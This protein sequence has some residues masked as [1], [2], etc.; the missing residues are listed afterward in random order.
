MSQLPIRVFEDQSDRAAA[1]AQTASATSDKAEAEITGAVMVALE[2]RPC[3][4]EWDV[5]SR[6]PLGG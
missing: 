2:R 1:T 3:S 6:I 5:I 4:Y